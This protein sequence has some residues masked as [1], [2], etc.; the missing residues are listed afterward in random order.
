MDASRIEVGPAK[1]FHNGS[2]LVIWAYGILLLLPVGA[3]LVAISLVKV[4]FLT[5][6]IPVVALAAT[7]WIVPLGQGN[8]YIA[9]RARG[10]SGAPAGESNCLVQLTLTPRLRKGIRALLEDADDFGILTFDEAGFTFT[11]D[12]IHIVVPRQNILQVHRQNVGLRGRFVYGSRIT[13]EVKG[14]DKI[15]YL[16][17]AE[18]SSA[19]IPESKRITRRLLEQ[20][21]QAAGTS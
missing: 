16:E 6:L 17:F 5:F 18:R 3:S 11:G 8:H 10:L 1:L 7:A 14:L 4:G 9:R 21:K 12:A 2:M 19:I 20:F 13:I 15:S